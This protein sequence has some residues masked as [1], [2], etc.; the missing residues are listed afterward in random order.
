MI[1]STFARPTAT[2]VNIKYIA[3]LLLLTGI[4]AL[5]GCGSTKIYNLD[6]T[7][8]YRGSL[9]NLSNVQQLVSRME[10]TLPN[11][12]KVN[13]K[14]MDEKEINQLLDEHSSMVVTTYVQMD[15][16]NMVY[17]TSR[18]DRY[19]DVAKMIKRQDKAMGKIQKFMANKKATQ[20]KLK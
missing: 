7:M 12:D 14:Q 9:F 10:G 17:Q 5:P 4:M 18:V 19:S 3:V 15:N 11:G 1:Q 20:L 8:V 6:K 16:R 2:T 13:L